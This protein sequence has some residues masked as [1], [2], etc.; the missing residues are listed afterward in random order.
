MS[1]FGPFLFQTKSDFETP[2]RYGY[3]GLG[4][5]VSE[6]HLG[7]ASIRS[8]CQRR[9]TLSAFDDYQRCCV[10]SESRITEPKTYLSLKDETRQ[11]KPRDRWS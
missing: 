10:Q 6:A 8:S 7:G 2:P 11:P 3:L 5:S 1:S 4:P 9:A